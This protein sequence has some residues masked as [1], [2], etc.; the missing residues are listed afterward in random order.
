MA[1]RYEYLVDYFLITCKKC[2][3]S[4]VDLG[5]DKCGEC[6]N[7]VK[8]ECND[9]GSEFDPHAFK[10]REMEECPPK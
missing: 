5:V 6:G 4:N 8:G 9:C 2:G 10:M 7:T 1:R 3:S